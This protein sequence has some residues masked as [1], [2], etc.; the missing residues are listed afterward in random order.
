MNSELFLEGESLAQGRGGVSH[1][2]VGCGMSPLVVSSQ[3]VVFPR[4]VCV[5]A[6]ANPLYSSW[7]SVIL[8]YAF[9]FIFLQTNLSLVENLLPS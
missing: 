6:I 9:Q 8:E 5:T 7:F 3:N 4:A 1:G 2:Q